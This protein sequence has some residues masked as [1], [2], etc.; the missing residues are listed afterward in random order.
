MAHK[1]SKATKKFEK[2]KLKPALERRKDFAK[3]KQRHKLQAKKKERAE[4][5][6]RNESVQDGSDTSNPQSSVTD[7]LNDDKYFQDGVQ[8][9]E[10]ASLRKGGKTPLKQPTGKRKRSED[11]GDTDGSTNELE[12]NE[13]RHASL[14]ESK[15]EN[16]LEDHKGQLNALAQKDPEFY[17]F[18]KEKDAELLDFND[19]DDLAG[20]DALSESDEDER[21]S[22][23]QKKNAGREEDKALDKS[24]VTAAMI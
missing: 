10:A 1:Q 12:A 6:A 16:E 5:R 2:N 3:V 18:L 22:K 13:V 21:P 23:K 14:F 15:E 7:K 11:E 8:I 9:P 20:V 19:D 24:A 17:K 4:K